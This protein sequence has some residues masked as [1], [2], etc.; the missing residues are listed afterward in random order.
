REDGATQ[1]TYALLDIDRRRQAE[2]QSRLAQASLARII[3]GAP[4]A[5][6]LH[7]AQSL[8][9]VKLNQAAAALAGRPEATML[10]G[11]PDQLF[12]AELGGRV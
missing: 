12:G 4:L 7:E 10:G 5:I 3:E 2:A 9:I 11:T 1:L 8:R 6:T